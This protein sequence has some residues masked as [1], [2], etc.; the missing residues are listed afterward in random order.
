MRQGDVSSAASV[1]V[2]TEEG[3]ASAGSAYEHIQTTVAF[4]P[5]EK[6]VTVKIKLIDDDHWSPQLTFHVKITNVDLGCLVAK[7]LVA[8]VFIAS[9][10]TYPI[11]VKPGTTDLRKL[12][13][14]VKAYIMVCT[15][16]TF[17]SLHLW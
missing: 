16:L 13:Q 15:G 10:D 11:N 6:L 3:S 14:F 7:P 8:T 9:T 12:S 17:C 2:S 4:K 1:K 5:F